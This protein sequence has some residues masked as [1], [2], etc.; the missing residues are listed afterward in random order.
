MQSWNA[1]TDEFGDFL[2]NVA[3]VI[4]QSGKLGIIDVVFGWAAFAA[5]I[6]QRELVALRSTHCANVLALIL[7]VDIHGLSVFGDWECLLG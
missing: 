7:R 3:S 4:G 1:D 5:F 2:V 6:A